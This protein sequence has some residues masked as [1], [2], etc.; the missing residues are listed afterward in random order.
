MCA[1]IA[2]VLQIDAIRIAMRMTVWTDASG[3]RQ[4]PRTCSDR[5]PPVPFG[6]CRFQLALS[7]RCP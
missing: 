6:S 5:F 7:R 4:Q 1:S 3:S 2:G